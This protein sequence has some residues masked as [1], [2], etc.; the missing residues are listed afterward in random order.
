MKPADIETEGQ[1]YC[2][3]CTTVFSGIMS[4]AILVS[5]SVSVLVRLVHFNVL[6]DTSN[7]N[8]TSVGNYSS[9]VCKWIRSSTRGWTIMLAKC[10]ALS[11][12]GC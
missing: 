6:S 12:I 7:M 11:Q 3:C 9:M 8:G 2:N 1:R 4:N 5:R 10:L